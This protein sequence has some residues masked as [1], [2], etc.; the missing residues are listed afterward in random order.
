MQGALLRSVSS[1][2]EP[3]PCALCTRSLP[4]R[5]SHIISEFLYK[6]LYDSKHR[7][8]QISA[9]PEKLNELL[10]KGLR[11]P[12][13]CDGCE[14]RLANFERYASMVLNGGAGIGIQQWEEDVLLS[15]LDYKKLKLFQLSILWRAGVSSS[16]AFSQ[17]SLGPHADQLRVML[18]SE[19][20]GPSHAYGCLMFTLKHD[21]QVA[22]DLIVPPTWTRLAGHFAYRFVFG[23]MVW[24]FVVS[25]HPPREFISANFLQEDGTCIVRLQDIQELTF[26]VKTVAKMRRLGK[27]ET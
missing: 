12:L 2:V 13:L 7:F 10:Q 6:T 25:K 16:Q 27:L 23:G 1:I 8:H 5:N 24:V 15:G 4:L 11:E 17:V 22:Q 19:N 20:P 21:G 18:D 3:V 9:T 14:Q 26:L